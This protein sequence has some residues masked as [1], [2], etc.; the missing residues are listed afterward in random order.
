MSI[1]SLTSK[2]IS[3]LGNPE[4]ITPLLIKDTATSYSLTQFAKR[5]GGS[6]E[7]TDK[8]IDEFGTMA[9]WLGGIPF[10]KKIL[11]KTLY[12]AAKLDPN[13]DVRV[14]QNEAHRQFAQKNA[15]GAVKEAFDFASKQTFCRR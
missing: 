8:F 1:S 13:T 10:F 15:T 5:D 3:I 4:A 2:T 11:D 14:I 7:S 12:K 6:I 9:I